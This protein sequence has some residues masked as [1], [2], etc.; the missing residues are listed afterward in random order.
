MVLAGYF[1]ILNVKVVMVLAGCYAVC[2]SCAPTSTNQI[3]TMELV[4]SA[5]LQ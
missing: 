4:A 5:N 1:F 3:Y 2:F